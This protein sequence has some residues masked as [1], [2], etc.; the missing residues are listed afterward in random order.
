MMPPQPH[1]VLCVACG[2]WHRAWS[3]S[4]NTFGLTTLWSDGFV[5][6]TM[7]PAPATIVTRCASCGAFFWL[8]DA[9]L[10]QPLRD[11]D[12]APAI[13]AIADAGASRE[14][15]I[16]ALRG[17][18]GVP[19][20]VARAIV[21]Q[22]RAITLEPDS[23]TTPGELRRAL[24][25][26]GARVE[27]RGQGV[28]PQ[29]SIPRATPDVDKPEESRYL[30]ALDAGVATS[31][32]RELALRTHAWWLGNHPFRATGRPWI[33]LEDRPSRVRE[34]VARLAAIVDVEDPHARL[35]KIECARQLGRFD[36]ALSLVT[37]TP[38]TEVQR[39]AGALWALARRG[40]RALAELW[41]RR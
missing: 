31:I 37:P 5:T 6:S 12:A 22:G 36:E 2:T 23:D 17:A 15:V 40:D 18:I 16:L 19:I 1:F 28:G 30:D 38:P 11:D 14:K 7:L 25:R 32:E 24:E 10:H 27:E 41:T 8:D 4:G 3:R 35:T 9:P 26:A 39:A 20:A 21:D 29:R 34:N 13:L 33:D